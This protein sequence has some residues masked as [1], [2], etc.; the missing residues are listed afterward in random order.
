[1]T[2]IGANGPVKRVQ[3]E[4]TII[5]ADGT[6]EKLGTITDSSWRWRFTPL[7]LLSRWRIHKANGR[8]TA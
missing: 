6:V 5:R 8:V 4:A 7:R 1:V 3:I 2:T